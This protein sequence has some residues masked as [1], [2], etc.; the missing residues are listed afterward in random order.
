MLFR[1]VAAKAI[2]FKEALDPAFGIYSGKV[3]E[4]AGALATSLQDRGW[5]IV[6]G[7]T[8]NHLMLVDVFSRGVLGST[9]EKALDRAGITINKNGIPFD[10]NPP[11]KPSGIRLGTPAITTRGM[12]RAEMV[13]IAEWIHQVLLHP[14]SEDRLRQVRSEVVALT[15]KFPIPQ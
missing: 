8:D 14:D 4:N 10:P 11:L 1:S 7:G 6:S 3:I 2:A 15:Q 9:A 5:R 12:G 13:Q